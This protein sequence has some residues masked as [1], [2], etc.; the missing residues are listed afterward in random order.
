MSPAR[1][2]SPTQTPLLVPRARL[3]LGIYSGLVFLSLLAFLWQAAT[4]QEADR[5]DWHPQPI[6]MA[7]RV[8]LMTYNMHSGVGLDNKY[9]LQRIARVV[10]AAAPDIL[11]MQVSMHT[12]SLACAGRRAG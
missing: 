3:Q 9:D 7:P 8:R 2:S 10:G 4:L 11:C 1:E 12:Y 5:T 6:K